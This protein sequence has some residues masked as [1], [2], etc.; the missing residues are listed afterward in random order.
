MEKAGVPI[1]FLAMASRTA[2]AWT[3]EGEFELPRDMAQIIGEDHPFLHEVG[4]DLLTLIHHPDSGKL[5]LSGWEP[6]KKESA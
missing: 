2:Q 1:V 3:A 6:E 4:E 5:L